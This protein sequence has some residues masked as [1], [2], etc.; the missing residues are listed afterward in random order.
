[1]PRPCGCVVPP[2][3]ST[4]VVRGGP[5]TCVRRDR[6]REE[7]RSPPVDPG[8]EPVPANRGPPPGRAPPQEVTARSPGTARRTR[9]RVDLGVFVGQAPPSRTC[10]SKVPPAPV[11]TGS[12]HVSAPWPK[13]PSPA[14]GACQG[15]YA[16]AGAG[17][18]GG[19]DRKAPSGRG[20]KSA[21][22][23][24]LPR[25]EGGGGKVSW[26]VKPSPHSRSYAQKK[27][28]RNVPTPCLHRP[29]IR[30]PGN[31]PAPDRRIAALLR[32]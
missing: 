14:Q 29:A 6:A 4:S 16:V 20:D 11:G 12:W 13:S 28:G 3:C 8:S 21:P 15:R 27:R 18:I 17:R 22:G 32:S 5:P 24:S 1:R 10:A 31:V 25:V 23:F 26:G 7:L 19:R 30:P 2:V 9:P